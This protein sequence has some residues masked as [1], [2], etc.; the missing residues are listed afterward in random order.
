MCKQTAVL[1]QLFVT[2]TFH[3]AKILEEFEFCGT[4]P[5]LLDFFFF[6]T[7]VT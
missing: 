2:A 1:T 3:L 6:F 4:Q 7:A 5:D